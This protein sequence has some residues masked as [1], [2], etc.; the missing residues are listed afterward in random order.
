MEEEEGGKQ[1]VG[2]WEWA[3]DNLGVPSALFSLPCFL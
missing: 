3:N 2:G 1:K